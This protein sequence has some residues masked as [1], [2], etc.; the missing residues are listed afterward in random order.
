MPDRDSV[1]WFVLLTEVAVRAFGPGFRLGI[2]DAKRNNSRKLARRVL[3][4]RC[5]DGDCGFAAGVCRPA[6]VPAHTTADLNV[7]RQNWP[8]YEL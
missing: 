8:V 1:R 4:M 2:S 7:E 6:G 3:Q 5:R